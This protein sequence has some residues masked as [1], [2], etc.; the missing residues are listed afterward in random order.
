[1]NEKIKLHYRDLP[2]P[3][4]GIVALE[5]RWEESEKIFFEVF[6]ANLDAS[7]VVKGKI[8]YKTASSDLSSA[9]PG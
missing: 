5:L 3:I 8:H 2:H 6:S 4:E 7:G 1:M 9:N